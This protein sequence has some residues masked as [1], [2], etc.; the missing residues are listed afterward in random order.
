MLLAAC[1]GGGSSDQAPVTAAA[2]PAANAINMLDGLWEH[3][4]GDFFEFSEDTLTYFIAS[5]DGTNCYS[6]VAVPLVQLSATTYQI[7][8]EFSA[9]E[10]TAMDDT[11]TWTLLDEDAAPEDEEDSLFFP[12]VEGLMS[13]DLNICTE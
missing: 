7:N 1:G 9:S 8:N 13:V 5:S 12:R 10:I 6:T 3:P 11:L 4:S 2:T